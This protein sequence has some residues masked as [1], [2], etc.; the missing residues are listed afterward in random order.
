M[1]V[2]LDADSL[3]QSLDVLLSDKTRRE[4]M[5]ISAQKYAVT[6]F[7]LSKIIDDTKASIAHMI[8]FSTIL[9]ILFILLFASML[10]LSFLTN[11]DDG[12]AS[13]SGP[14]GTFKLISRILFMLT[15]LYFLVTRANQFYVAYKG[16]VLF[17]LLF[18]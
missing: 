13:L 11:Y 9:S 14:W 10:N 4:R 5:A 15:G 12:V 17:L 6:S 1:F 2:N 18:F 8:R 7:S 3:A 16:P